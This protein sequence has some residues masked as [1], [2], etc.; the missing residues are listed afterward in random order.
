MIT[1]NAV[2][3]RYIRFLSTENANKLKK[4]ESNPNTAENAINISGTL[5]KILSFCL[6]ETEILSF[7][8]IPFLPETFFNIYAPPYTINVPIV[9]PVFSEDAIIISQ[10]VIF[11]LSTCSGL[12]F[13]YI[14]VLCLTF[15][16]SESLLAESELKA[17]VI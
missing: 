17:D 16:K 10:S 2:V 5:L 9:A 15:C 6:M 13:M 1:K 3:K 14:T 12:S 8:S 4:V 11:S 7:S